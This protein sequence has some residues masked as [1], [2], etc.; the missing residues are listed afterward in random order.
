MITFFTILLLILI[1][2]IFSLF[3]RLAGGILK[4]ALKLIICLPCALLCAI[5]GIIMCCTLVLIP[6][7]IGCFRL[8]AGLM[9]PFRACFL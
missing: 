5:V 6:L 9:N 7:G 4:L 8:A 1:I 3:F 2:G